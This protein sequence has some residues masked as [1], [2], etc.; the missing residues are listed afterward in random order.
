MRN[1]PNPAEALVQL[2]RHE[3]HAARQASWRQAIAAL[4]QSAGRLGPPPLDGVDERVLESSAHVAVE[5]GLADDLD[6]IAPGSAAV[7]LYELSSCL[8]AGQ[9]KRELRRKVFSRLYEGTASTFATVASRMALGSAKPLESPT[10]RARVALCFDLPAG[11]SVDTAPL[12]LA[13]ATRFELREA[14]LSWPSTQALPAR[15]LAA[16]VLEHA[17]REAV[18]RHQLGD[19]HPLGVLR[20]EEL[21][22][23]FRRLLQDREPLVWRHAA[24]ARGLLASVH[25]PTRE[26]VVAALEPTLSPTEWRRAA[27]SLVS[28]LIDNDDETLQSCRAILDGELAKR[29]PGLVATM[30]LGLPRVVEAEPDRAEELLDRLATTRRPD[31]AEA[32]ARLFMEVSLPGF[33]VGAAAVLRDA[34]AERARSDTPLGRALSARSLRLLSPGEVDESSISQQVK[35]AL[36]AFETDGAKR[37]YDLATAAISEAHQVAAFIETLEP[38][39][40]AASPQA[41]AALQDIDAAAVERPTLANL[42]LLGRRAGE[43]DTSVQP[44]ERLYNRLGQWVLDGAQKA[45]RTEWTRDGATADQKRLVVLLHLVDAESVARESESH[46]LVTRLRRSIGVLIER[47]SHG[48]DAAV[49]RLLCAALARTFDAAVREGVAQSSDLALVLATKLD[50]GYSVATIAEASTNPDVAGPIGALAAFMNPELHDAGEHADTYGDISVDASML[51]RAEV[52]ELLRVTRRVVRLSEGLSGGGGYRSEALRRV[53]FRLGRALEAVA[54]AR[55]QSELVEQNGTGRVIIDELEATVEAFADLAR[56]ARRR[57]L[58]SADTTLDVDVTTDAPPLSSLLDR[59]V[60]GGVPANE[61]QLA[62]SAHELVAPLP[63][64]LGRVVEQVLHRIN[65]L[66]TSPGSDVYA[67][68]LEKRRA[69]L[70]AWLLPRRTLGSFYVL[71]PLGSG[72]V[73]SVFMVRRQEERHDAK[74]ESFALKVP[75]YDPTTAR[76]LSEQ[77]FLQLFREEAGALLGLPSHP[78]LARFVTFDLSARPKPILVME[79]IRGASLERLIRSS[80][81]SSER[82]FAYLD[83]ILAGLEAMHGVGV[84]HL[85][86]KPS[87]VILRDGTTPVLVDFGLSGRQLRPGCGT[88]E[89]TAPEVLGVTTEGVVPSAPPA[90]IYAFGCLAYEMLTGELL[91]DAGDELALVAAHVSH[92]GWPDKLARLGNQ[93]ECSRVARMLG[94]CLRRDPRL[95]PSA[96]ELRKLLAPESVRLAGAEW[97]LRPTMQ[98]AI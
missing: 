36:L 10:L 28:S 87:N 82:A 12:A 90:D 9:T 67:V 27:V 64:F 42:L 88:I 11:S 62:S 89:Y 73:S 65:G 6:W 96:T 18:V 17:A 61:T 70:P 44:M 30:V 46:P 50:D 2:S 91:F 41:L 75:E 4:A 14:W 13:F 24:V 77:E 16:Q 53:V 43:T 86:V 72:G 48:P 25:G 60:R 59:S 15:R 76:S 57:L 45:T 49:H 66:P 40:H 98:V 69:P 71:R 52:E 34:L 51:H 1:R 3:D 54:L 81:I 38:G 47:L 93:P 63:Q 94:M 29:D 55:G 78:N 26:E 58:G 39:N 32:V 85:D 83:G 79:L 74:A 80:S 20:G 8:P 19:A 97:P 33:G 5:T 31:V 56:S 92:D 95:R 22:P 23:V 68:P 35:A 37:A 7:A 84:G 21:R